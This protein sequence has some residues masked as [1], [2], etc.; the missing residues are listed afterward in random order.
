MI[1]RILEEGQWEVPDSSMEKI[2]KLDDTLE[3]A[4]N[5]GD[6]IAFKSSLDA[7]IVKIKELGTKVEDD[8]ILPSDLMLPGGEY[9]LEETKQLLQEEI[10]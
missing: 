7:I 1:V 10:N 3:D 9:S 4:L 6:E 5:S 8:R 2:E